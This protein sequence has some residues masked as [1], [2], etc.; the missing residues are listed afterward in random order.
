MTPAVD[1]RFVMVVT[2]SD[3][4]GLH[5]P[6][7]YARSWGGPGTEEGA[8]AFHEA[9]REDY[10]DVHFMGSLDV[11]LSGFEAAIPRGRFFRSDPDGYAH[12]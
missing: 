5:P 11:E 9:A 10:S 1:L 6:R 3:K 12:I 4:R 8:R 2:A 7:K